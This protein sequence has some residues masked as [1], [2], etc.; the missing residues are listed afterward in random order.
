LTDRLAAVLA[1]MD[2]TLVDSHV[3][4]ERHWRRLA[5]RHGLDPAPF[6]ATAHGRR[7]SD[8][9]R[10]LAPHLDAV[11]EAAELDAGEEA[12]LDGLRA[13]P[14]AAEL[15]ARLPAGAVAVV[16]S[17]HR[18]LASSRL[19]AVGLPV[20]GTMVCGD[21]ITH[22]KP[23]PE[24][25]LRAAAELGVAAA[26][27]LVLEDVPAGVAAGIAAGALVVAVETTYPPERLA[28]AAATVPDL[29][30]LD[31]VLARLGRILPA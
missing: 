4:V 15:L 14:G 16:T 13:V 26:D 10:E 12:D 18:S 1:D 24:G 28:A 7:S 30:D 17:A 25:Y 11:A 5:A 6:L 2:G 21:E 19:A 20:P 31:A 27:C 29:R 23:D 8:V 9:I 3:V 22:G